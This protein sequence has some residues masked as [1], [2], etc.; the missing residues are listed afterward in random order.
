MLLLLLLA[1]G[2]RS[3]SGAGPASSEIVSC[4]DQWQQGLEA[5]QHQEWTQAESLFAGAVRTC[6]Q[7]ERARKYYSD[8]LWHRGAWDDATR[9]M[10]EAVNLSGGDPALL[11]RLGEMYIAQGYFDEAEACAAESLSRQVDLAGAWA[12]SGDIHWQ[13]GRRSAAIDDYHRALSLQSGSPRVQLA[14][15]RASFAENDPEQA[16]VTLHALKD[17]TPSAELSHDVFYLEGMIH[18]SLRRYEDAARSFREVAQR[19]QGGSLLFYEIANA[20]MLSGHPEP[21]RRAAQ[22]ALAWD[23]AHEPTRQLLAQINSMQIRMAA[24]AVRLPK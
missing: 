3:L 17:S 19:G 5:L 24:N 16:L 1:S 8:V 12:L 20:E 14:L 6:P 4:R 15:A 13:H 9:Q 23:A 7:D 10:Q 21:A 11:V 2:C 22:I 18:K